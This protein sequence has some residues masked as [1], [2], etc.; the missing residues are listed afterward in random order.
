VAKTFANAT[1]TPEDLNLTTLVASVWSKTKT[2]TENELTHTHEQNKID[3]E[4][5]WQTKA[6]AIQQDF[7]A[8]GRNGKVFTTRQSQWLITA[9][10]NLA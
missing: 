7:L 4:R 8:Q 3:D 6:D 5:E 2:H 10:D 1:F 9:A